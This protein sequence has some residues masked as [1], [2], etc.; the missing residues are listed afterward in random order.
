MCPSCR[1]VVGR[2][3][4]SC[5]IFPV[6][7]SGSARASSKT[8]TSDIRRSIAP[9]CRRKSMQT[10]IASKEIGKETNL[11]QARADGPFFDPRR[12]QVGPRIRCLVPIFGHSALLELILWSIARYSEVRSDHQRD[13]SRAASPAATGWF[14]LRV[15]WHLYTTRS[16]SS[17]G[18]NL[19]P[20]EGYGPAT[21]AWFMRR[22]QKKPGASSRSSRQSAW[23]CWSYRASRRTLRPYPG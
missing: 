17:L 18:A 2:G 22:G 6:A 20:F 23:S 4:I 9:C 14:K 15:P 7:V 1:L 13:W 21:A 19:G 10:L 3:G 12:F 8:T 11:G 5:W 16:Y